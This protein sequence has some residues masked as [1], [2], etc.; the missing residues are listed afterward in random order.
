ML[1]E[2]MKPWLLEVNSSPAMSMETDIDLLVKPALIKDAI[3]LCPFESYQD[4]LERSRS[5]QTSTTKTSNIHKNFFSKRTTAMNKKDE[6]VSAPIA[7]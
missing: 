7:S 5:K 1:D 3:N 2:A 6:G 4:W